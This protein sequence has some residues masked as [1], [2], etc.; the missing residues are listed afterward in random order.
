MSR[1]PDCVFIVLAGIS[2]VL[3]LIVARGGSDLTDAVARWF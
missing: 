1:L 2:A 3:A